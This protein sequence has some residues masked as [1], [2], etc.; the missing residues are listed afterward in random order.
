MKV[1]VLGGTGHI[2]TSI[3]RLLLRKKHVVTCFNRGLAGPTPPSVRLIKGDRLQRSAFEAQM[4]N[5]QFDAVIDMICFTEADA[6]SSLR[7]FARVEHFVH[8]STVCTYGVDYDT[9]PVSEDHPLRPTTDYGRG[10]V[11]ADRVFMDAH[12]QEGFPVTILKPSTTYGPQMGLLRQLAIEFSWIDRIRKGKPILVVGDGNARHQFMHV[13]DAALGF[14]GVLGKPQCIGKIYNL[15]K[16][17]FVTWADYHR[18]A[19]KV[20]G[21][22]VELVGVALA[23]LVAIDKKR[24]EICRQ[25]FAHNTYYSAERIFRDV[26]EF[27]PQVSLEA[28]MQQV[29]R[30]LDRANRIPNCEDEDWEDR[31]V[32]AQRQIRS[33]GMRSTKQRR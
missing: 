4:K 17:G 23:D 33:V 13:D 5:E 28:G 19:M 24:F 32:G 8:C 21:R 15:V 1:L 31:I 7:A 20:L 22:Q 27:R 14:V 16:H 11:A 12:R 3:V 30:A 2:S 26:A 18:K 9:L 10:K 25:I 29:I 6:R